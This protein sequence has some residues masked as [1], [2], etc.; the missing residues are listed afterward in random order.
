MG[1]ALEVMDDVVDNFLPSVHAVF[2]FLVYILY[3]IPAEI[4]R[5]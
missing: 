2:P 4:A 3:P 1:F 5:R